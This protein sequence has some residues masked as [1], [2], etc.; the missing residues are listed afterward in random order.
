MPQN[1]YMEI[2]RNS[3]GQ[4]MDY[5][6]RKAKKSRREN[7]KD[8]KKAHSI[9]GIKAKIFAKKSLIAKKNENKISQT[10]RETG[11]KNR[12]FNQKDAMPAFLLE[13]DQL[14]NK[15][16]TRLFKQKRL[17]KQGKWTVPINNVNPYANEDIHIDNESMQ[18]C[19][20]KGKKIVTKVTFTHPSLPRKLPKYEKFIR[21]TGLRMSKAN[22]THPQLMATFQLEI[23]KVN[24]NPQGRIYTGLGIITKGT[25]LEVNVSEIGLVT[26]CGNIIRGKYAQVTNNPENDGVVNAILLS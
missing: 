18:D 14:H 21:P 20:K 10:L 22:V 23:L 13:R 9:F 25:I 15:P 16:L 12:K 2:F 7:Y 17:D 5:H 6:Y 8:T 19:K 24:V 1:E 26:S 11:I 3:Y 4:R